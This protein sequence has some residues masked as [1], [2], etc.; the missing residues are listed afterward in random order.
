[1]GSQAWFKHHICSVKYS[2]D[3]VK[4]TFCFQHILMSYIIYSTT[5]QMRE[6]MESI[7]LYLHVHCKLN[8][9]CE[10][11]S[12]LS[13]PPPPTNSTLTC[14]SCGTVSTGFSQIRNINMFMTGVGEEQFCF[15]CS[16]S[17]SLICNFFVFYPKKEGG[18]GSPGPSPNSATV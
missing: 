12:P 17:F 8:Y 10:K 9:D 6:N 15:V 7:N 3:L 14:L 2:N 18:G 13:F 11:R 16:A 1:M 5:E 4:Y